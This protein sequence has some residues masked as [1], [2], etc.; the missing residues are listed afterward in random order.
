M[1]LLEK[2]H[3]RLLLLLLPGSTWLEVVVEPMGTVFVRVILDGEDCEREGA[4]VYIIWVTEYE[5]YREIKKG[6]IC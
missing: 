1:C 3:I 6:R 2:C 4:C 5:D